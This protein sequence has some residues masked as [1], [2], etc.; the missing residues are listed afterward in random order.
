VYCS[1]GRGTVCGAAVAA[2]Q[3]VL[4]DATTAARQ[5]T[6]VAGADGGADAFFAMVFAGARIGEPIVWRGPFVLASPE[7]LRATMEAVYSGRFPPKRAAWD[8]KRAAARPSAE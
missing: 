4:L 7:E 3:V 5:L 6:L 2:H 8:Y 1:R